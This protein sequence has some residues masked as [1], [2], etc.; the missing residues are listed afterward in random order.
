[1]S[2]YFNIYVILKYFALNRGDD[3]EWAYCFDIHINA[4][5]AVF[6]ILHMAQES[7]IYGEWTCTPIN[8]QPTRLNYSR[9][10]KT[11]FRF[12]L[13]FFYF[14]LWLIDFMI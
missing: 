3:L 9:R 4:F 10:E 13:A 12:T 14:S 1:M 11:F 5:F 6:I 8:W 2:K 7:E